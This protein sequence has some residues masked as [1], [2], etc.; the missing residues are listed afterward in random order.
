MTSRH[1]RPRTATRRRLRR[2]RHRALHPRQVAVRRRQGHPDGAGRPARPRGARRRA[3]H[4]P[5][6]QGHLRRVQRPQGVADPGRRRTASGRSSSTSGSSTSSRRSPP[7]H[8]EGNKGT[9]EG[10]YYVPG[11]PRAGRARAPSRCATTR[12]AP[13]CAGPAR[14]PP[15]TAPPLAGAK[16]ELWHADDD[17]FYSQFA[18]GIPEWNLRGTV[19]RRRRRRVRDPHDAARAVPDPDRRLLRQADRR[20]RLARLAPGPPAREGLGARPRAAHRP[21]V[22]PRRRAQRRRHRLGGQA[23]ADPRP[24]AARPTAPA[25]RCTYDFVL[26]PARG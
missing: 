4:H 13:R 11:R 24:R 16:V 1:H 26:D 21:A 6:A 7:Q 12:P 10:P 19:H 2:Q 20:G 15:P 3:R 25:S 18:P 14:S 17:G 8:R 5:Q 9:I 22:L 23:R